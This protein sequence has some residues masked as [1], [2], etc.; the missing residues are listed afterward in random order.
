[1][2][3]SPE[4][5]RSPTQAPRPC[6]SRGRVKQTPR[7]AACRQASLQYGAIAGLSRRAG[8]VEAG[9][10]RVVLVLDEWEQHRWWVGRAGAWRW[11]S[12]GGGVAEVGGQRE[13]GSALRVDQ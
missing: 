7:S 2:W 9:V 5:G 13:H 10:A 3:Q 1:M 8:P 4:R 6:S 11:R 12:L